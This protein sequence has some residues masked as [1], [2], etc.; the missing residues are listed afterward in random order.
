MLYIRRHGMSTKIIDVSELTDDELSSI[1]SEIQEEK[2]KRTS[3]KLDAKIYS[4]LTDLE[5][6]HAMY[7]SV[8]SGVNMYRDRTLCSFVTAHQV[9]FL[10]LERVNKAL[11]DERMALES[12]KVRKSS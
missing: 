11:F 6:G 10:T 9:V 3:A 4:D 2:R 1:T 12:H 5:L 8:S 7:I